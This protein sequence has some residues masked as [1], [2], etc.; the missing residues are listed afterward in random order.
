MP[1]KYRHI[2]DYEKE[3]IKMYEQGMSL[4]RIG[5]RLGFTLKE[6]RDFKTRYNKKQRMIAENQYTR[7]ADYAKRKENCHRRFKSWTNLPK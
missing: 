2:S 4:R 1:R 3:I 7:K 6:M 5:E